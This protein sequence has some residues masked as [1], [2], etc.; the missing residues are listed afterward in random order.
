MTRGGG[1]A[2]LLKVVGPERP[3][4]VCVPIL[5]RRQHTLAMQF[6]YCKCRALNLSW[7]K[8]TQQIP[9]SRFPSGYHALSNAPFF[10]LPYFK[11]SGSKI[12]KSPSKSRPQPSVVLCISPPE[13]PLPLER[14]EDRRAYRDLRLFYSAFYLNPRLPRTC[15]WFGFVSLKGRGLVT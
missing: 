9:L 14:A 8:E 11:P 10:L 15:F 1:S 3:F 4:P 5:K 13:N 7:M 12:H 6:C 2:V